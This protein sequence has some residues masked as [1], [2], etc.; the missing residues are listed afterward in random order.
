[1]FTKRKKSFYLLGIILL[2][3]ASIAQVQA[4]P[5]N[6]QIR[7]QRIN[8]QRHNSVD[9]AIEYIAQ[10]TGKSVDEIRR[11]LDDSRQSEQSSDAQAQATIL[12]FHD[13]NFMGFGGHWTN[14]LPNNCYGS[15]KAWAMWETDGGNGQIEFWGNQPLG[16][17]NSS[18]QCPSGAE[19]CLFTASATLFLEDEIWSYNVNAVD[20]WN[21]TNNY[22]NWCEA[23]T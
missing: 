21:W 5:L 7:E 14:Y 9:E 1:M 20:W 11:Q 17:W 2:L 19:G 18:W 10:Q 6:A 16:T 12:S 3:M 8:I 22:A 13:E 4:A 15:G 23:W